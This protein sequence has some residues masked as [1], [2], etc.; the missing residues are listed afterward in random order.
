MPER[1]AETHLV[2]PAIRGQ[3][4]DEG[5]VKELRDTYENCARLG[6]IEALDELDATVQNE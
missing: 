5:L 3:V 1:L 4:L 2:H 6:V